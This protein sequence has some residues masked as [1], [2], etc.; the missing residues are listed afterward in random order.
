MRTK[1]APPWV[2]G[3][4]EHMGLLLG[5]SEVGGRTSAHSPRE[6]LWDVSVGMALSATL[7]V[8]LPAKRRREPRKNG[9]SLVPEYDR[10]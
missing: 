8:T 3:P 5:T 2:V 6:S 9:E 4:Q 7:A 1:A 10:V